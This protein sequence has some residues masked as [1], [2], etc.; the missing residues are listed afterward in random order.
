MRFTRTNCAFPWNGE[1]LTFT[2]PLPEDMRKYAENADIFSLP[3]LPPS[4]GD[5]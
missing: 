2:A 3:N 5:W 4:A 1:E